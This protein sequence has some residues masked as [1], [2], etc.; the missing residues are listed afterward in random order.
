[1]HVASA[2]YTVYLVYAHDGILNFRKYN[3]LKN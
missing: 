2:Q 3:T 1:M